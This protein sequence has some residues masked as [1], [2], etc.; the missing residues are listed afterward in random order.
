MALAAVVS[1]ALV[2]RSNDEIAAV[3]N[4]CETRLDAAFVKLGSFP[5]SESSRWDGTEYCSADACKTANCTITI[6]GTV[7][8]IIDDTKT[9]VSTVNGTAN[10]VLG[11]GVADVVVVSHKRLR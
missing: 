3:L 10:T 6:C 1:P 11:Q 9:A 4:T 2:S 7:V 5:A 8:G